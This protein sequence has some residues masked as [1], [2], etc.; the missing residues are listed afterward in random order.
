MSTVFQPFKLISKN[1]IL[2]HTL[3]KTIL[4]QLIFTKKQEIVSY[5]TWFQALMA[6]FGSLFYSEIMHL[7]PCILC[8]YQRILMYPLVVIVAVAILKKDKNLPYFVLPF[9]IIG[10]LFALFHYLLQMGIIPDAIAPCTAGISCT[11]R[12]IEYFGFIT[13][14]FLSLCAFILITSCMFVFLKDSKSKQ[15]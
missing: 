5:I 13:I 6:M 10:S 2:N 3:I 9:S 11:D 1:T 12:F 8:W 4:N 15:H 7:A 14:P